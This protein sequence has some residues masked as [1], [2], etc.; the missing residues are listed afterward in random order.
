MG[1]YSYEIFMFQMIYFHVC[2]ALFPEKGALVW[3]IAYMIV[4]VIIC[5]VPV[6]LYKNR[7]YKI[8]D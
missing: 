5:I 2:K 8:I 7:S 1:K 3:Q 4:A 6:V